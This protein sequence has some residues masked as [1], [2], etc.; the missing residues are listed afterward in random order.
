MTDGQISNRYPFSEGMANLLAKHTCL[1][2]QRTSASLMQEMGGYEQDEQ[3][4]K[5]IKFF[6]HP[7]PWHLKARG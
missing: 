3:K 4:K 1:L 5:K 7:F 6:F 2:Q